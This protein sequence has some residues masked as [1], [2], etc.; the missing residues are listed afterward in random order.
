MH[1]KLIPLTILATIGLSA[2]STRPVV[3]ETPAPVVVAVPAPPP[4]A[5][6]MPPP[7]PAPMPAPMPDMTSLHD[8]VHDAL[9]ADLGSAANGIEVRVEGSTVYLSGHV[10]TQAG[11]DRAHEVAHGVSG[12]STVDHSG[13]KV[14]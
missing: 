5:E 12:V 9:V 11:H 7:M 13:L 2:C 14:P 10:P 8:R 3:V 6:P 4:M 1:L